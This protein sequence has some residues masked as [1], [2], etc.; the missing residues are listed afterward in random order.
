[1]NQINVYIEVLFFNII[2]CIC[3]FTMF[4]YERDIVTS[5]SGYGSKF[6][7]IIVHNFW[8]F[9]FRV[10]TDNVPLKNVQKIPFSLERYEILYCSVSTIW[11]M[12]GLIDFFKKC[13]L[14]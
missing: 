13:K 6:A 4:I 3:Y 2:Y 1:M 8:K 14:L 7:Q 5:I 9:G 10:I 12:V 11:L